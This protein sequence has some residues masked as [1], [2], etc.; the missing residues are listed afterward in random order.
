M[1]KL[2]PEMRRALREAQ[3]WYG[4]LYAPGGSR[5]VCELHTARA[6]VR[7]G[8]LIFRGGRYE[9]TPNGLHAAEPFCR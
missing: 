1:E 9:V 8:W 6:M 7:S 4:G 3:V 2:F 5:P